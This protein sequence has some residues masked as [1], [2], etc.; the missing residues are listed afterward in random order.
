MCPLFSTA[1]PLH[2]ELKSEGLPV[3]DSAT[4]ARASQHHQQQIYFLLAKIIPTKYLSMPLPSI[5]LSLSGFSILVWPINISFLPKSFH[6][7]IFPCFAKIYLLLAKINPCHHRH[8]CP[9]HQHC[10]ILP[11]FVF[12]NPHQLSKINPWMPFSYHFQILP[13]SILIHCHVSQ[14]ECHILPIISFQPYRPTSPSIICSQSQII[15]PHILQTIQFASTQKMMARTWGMFKC[16]LLLILASKTGESCQL[17]INFQIF[18]AP[19]TEEKLSK[20]IQH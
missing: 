8:V 6:C 2:N 13:L 12:L 7:H 15:L 4:S 20:F 14:S 16:P 18:L 17:F 3:S 10:H 1:L 11:I 19:S 9:C 5:Y